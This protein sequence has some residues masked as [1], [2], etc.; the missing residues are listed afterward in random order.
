ME[1]PARRD[2]AVTAL[3]VADLLAGAEDDRSAT[4]LTG[5]GRGASAGDILDTGTPV[6]AVL[7]DGPSLSGTALDGRSAL[8]A[9][10]APGGGPALGGGAG[11]GTGLGTGDAAD[12]RG[13][14]GSTTTAGGAA[15]TAAPGTGGAGRRSRR[16]R[17]A[18]ATRVDA[19]DLLAGRTRDTPAATPAPAAQHRGH[20]GHPAVGRA[21]DGG[22]ARPAPGPAG[23]RRTRAHPSSAGHPPSADA[24][25]HTA[26]AD[27]TPDDDGWLSAEIAASRRSGRHGAGAGT[28]VADLLAAVALDAPAGGGRR[29][30]PDAAPDAGS[31][32]AGPT[33]AGP[34]SA[35]PASANPASANPAPPNHVSAKSAS[36]RPSGRGTDDPARPG[37]PESGRAEPGTNGRAEPGTD[38][39]AEPGPGGD[40]LFR[41]AGDA[42]RPWHGGGPTSADEARSALQDLLRSASAD[43]G[44]D[45]D[46]RGPTAPTRTAASPVWPT[47]G[48]AGPPPDGPRPAPPRTPRTRTRPAPA[49]GT[50]TP[51]TS[52]TRSTPAVRRAGPG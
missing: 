3:S 46:G 12:G 28:S 49:P 9:G 27:P 4:P 31:G 42:G 35:S 50:T 37:R 24:P 40:D 18:D 33:P 26:P 11:T 45:A 41:A 52:P 10:T 30:E 13:T 44:P 17:A 43:R 25:G 47:T 1:T 19:A 2:P 6:P 21:A 5:F 36:P 14:R 20:R 15:G 38:G 8:D 7:D 51:T 39:R 16:D 29:R 48:P 34:A 22:H 23:A 32:T